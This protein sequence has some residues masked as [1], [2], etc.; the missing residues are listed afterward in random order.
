MTPLV[1]LILVV[2]VT[3]IDGCAQSPNPYVPGY[4][5]DCKYETCQLVKM[6]PKIPRDEQ[7]ILKVTS[8]QGSKDIKVIKEAKQTKQT[9][10]N[11]EFKDDNMITRQLDIL[12]VCIAIL[13]SLVFTNNKA[14]TTCIN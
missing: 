9:N 13:V 12:E 4:G 7:T 14:L 8:T 2:N 1:L 6:P 5:Y 10:A 11:T 3:V